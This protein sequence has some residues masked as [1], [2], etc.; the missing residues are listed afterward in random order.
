LKAPM[1]ILTSSNGV[2]FLTVDS[3]SKYELMKIEPSHVPS[4]LI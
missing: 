1:V 2:K 3:Q 4:S